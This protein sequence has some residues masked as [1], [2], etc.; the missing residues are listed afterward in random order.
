MSGAS[1]PTASSR[2]PVSAFA[3][4]P[5]G[6]SRMSMTSDNPTG[7]GPPR[8]I[9]TGKN[10]RP[11]ASGRSHFGFL[12]A[13]LADLGHP[14]A[15]TCRPEADWLWAVATGR[16]ASSRSTIR[17]TTT[18]ASFRDVFSRCYEAA[19]VPD[20][21]FKRPGGATTWALRLTARGFRPNFV[22]Q[23]PLDSSL[24][25]RTSVKRERMVPPA[26]NQLGELDD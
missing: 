11:P 20:S 19:T 26:I 10:P 14:H 25:Q 1:A 7:P 22:G 8:D 16:T 2:S 3:G 12:D 13:E 9:A 17:F 5:P 21:C 24:P 6:M 15:A 4:P 18:A 23:L